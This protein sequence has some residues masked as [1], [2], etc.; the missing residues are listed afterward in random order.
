MVRTPLLLAAF[1]AAIPAA[2]ALAQSSDCESY[3]VNAPL[4][5]M[6]NNPG[7]W[8]S[9][10][11]VLSD[12]QIVCVGEVQDTTG[13]QWGNVVSKSEADGSA[14][15][16][17]DGWSNMRYLS[18]AS[19]AAAP[20]NPEPAPDTGQDTA[21]A[22][23][24]PEPAE[25]G[26]GGTADTSATTEPAPTTASGAVPAFDEVWTT[27]PFPLRGRSLEELANAIPLF[28]PIDDLP[29]DV[30]QKPCTSCHQWTK[31]R[32]C[33]QGNGYV[34]NPADILRISHPHGGPV[35]N[36]LSKWAAAGC[37]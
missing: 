25:T 31:D 33:Q 20:E 17:V 30:W 29:D 22:P 36:A 18:P 16:A 24:A 32:L 23:T 26:D 13:Q 2:A 6:R 14:A 15:E 34:G 21:P 9:I 10:V 5:N 27:G 11:D 12:G 3:K 4:L 35:K 7:V 1:L 28:A 8:G 37:P 19:M